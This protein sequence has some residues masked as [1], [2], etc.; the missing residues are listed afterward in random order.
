MWFEDNDK[1]VR[2]PTPK[3]FERLVK[4]LEDNDAVLFESISLPTLKPVV[5]A[6]KPAPEPA[7]LS[8]PAGGAM[9]DDFLD[10]DDIEAE[11]D[12]LGD[13]PDVL[14]E[15]IRQLELE[16]SRKS[17]AIAA[18]DQQISVLQNELSELEAKLTGTAPKQTR[19]TYES[20]EVYKARYEKALRDL[21]SLKQ[22]LSASGKLKRV[23]AK[24]ARVIKPPQTGL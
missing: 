8:L 22:S 11:I 21:N 19:P 5:E 16:G 15:K 20:V 10:E 17:D 12:S 23:S 24:S 3:G 6:A 14:R 4:N 18:K 1:F 13:D 2:A 7:P 9:S